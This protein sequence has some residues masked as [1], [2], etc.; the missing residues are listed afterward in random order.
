MEFAQFKN[1][2]AAEFKIN[3]NGYKEKQLKRR[4][5]SL[6]TTLHMKNYADYLELLQ[7]DE[8][9]LR[10]FLDRVTINVSE[11]FRNPDI[12]KQ[13]EE[14]TLPY[15][16]KQRQPLKIWSAACADGSEPYSL[17]ILLEDLTP[18]I[19]HKLLASDM[20]KKIL[21]VAKRG[22]YSPNTTRNVSPE[23]LKRYFETSEVKLQLKRDIISKVDFKQHDLLS[24]GFGRD[25]DLII[26]RNVTIYFTSE[27]QEELY[28][29][30]HQAL[31]R[32]GVLF[33]GA[34][35]SILRYQEL[36]FKKISP[37]FYGKA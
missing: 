26:C 20:D 19:K 11:F 1:K 12:F 2:V 22:L 23:R 28:K 35:E 7:S 31:A 33:I 36:G 27:T 5:D 17:A 4:I 30:F 34:T 24:D 9:N 18:G 10:R 13:L 8:N 21:E 37:W 6:T 25:F 32:H 15:L 14:K 3:L 29:K 16:L